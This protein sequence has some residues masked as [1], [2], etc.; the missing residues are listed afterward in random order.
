MTANGFDHV[1]KIS[2]S[3]EDYAEWRLYVNSVLIETKRGGFNVEFQWDNPLSITSTNVLDVKVL[4]KIT[5]DSLTF[6]STIYGF[7]GV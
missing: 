3:G 7:N 1:T 5:W 4:H 2:C 6:D